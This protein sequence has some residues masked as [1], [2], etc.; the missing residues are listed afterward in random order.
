[1]E[2]VSSFEKLPEPLL[3]VYLDTNPGES[4]NQ[5]HAPSYLSWLKDEARSIARD[6]PAP[7]RKVFHEQVDRVAS[8]LRDQESHERGLLIFAGPATW[9]ELPVKLTLQNELHWGRPA[10]SQIRSLL[11]AHRP[12]CMVAVDRAGA[13][14]FRYHVGEIT[15]YPEQKIRIDTSQWKKKDHAHMARRRTHMPHGPERDAFRQ[16]VEAQ[17][18]RWS[19]KVAGHATTLCQKEG[20]TSI[21]LIGSKR[22]VDMVQSG[23]PSEYHERVM[24]VAKDLARI[25]SAELQR[26]LAPEIAEWEKDFLCSRIERLL[27]RDRDTVLGIEETLAQI[28]IGAVRSVMLARGFEA[29]L[30]Q[31]VQCGFI[32]SSQDAVCSSCGA[33]RKGI[34]FREALEELVRAN[35]TELVVVDGDVAQ[36]LIE[37]GGMG[38]WLRRPRR[39]YEVPSTSARL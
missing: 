33:R 26:R 24:L 39:D 20:L 37:S 36:R 11:E 21:I 27:D 14:F 6:V 28:Q 18:R 25:P 35:H 10:L 1:M 12:S 15:E 5:G 19:A 23:F 3:T 9:K 31:C 4:N 29:N 16:R 22:L 2:R 7:E 30:R 34:P 8:F 38:G 17:Y 13:R 32:T